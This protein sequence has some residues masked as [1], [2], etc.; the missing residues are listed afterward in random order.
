MAHNPACERFLPLLS[1]YI[2]GELSPAERG[3]VER[4]LSACLVCTG[5][6]A[7]LRAEGG[8]I[9]VGLEMAADEVD[10]SGFAQAVLARVT[11]ERPP[12]LER[13]R[14]SV[15]EFFTYRHGMMMTSL[16]T[17][18]VVLLVAVPLLLRGRAPVGYAQ[19]RMELQAVKMAEEVH[20]KPVVL[21]A[22]EGGDSIVWYGKT[23][24]QDEESGED[25]EEDVRRDGR[26]PGTTGLE[27][28]PPK[29]GE[30]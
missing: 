26:R 19:E 9:R 3:H 13:L 7:D 28:P 23:G 20:V 14:I 2:D 17:A 27:K 15:S 24:E 4:H 8:L 1:P 18:A 21:Q 30:L 25:E 11:P 5:R 22:D 12:L 6:V 16:A 10:F 29:G